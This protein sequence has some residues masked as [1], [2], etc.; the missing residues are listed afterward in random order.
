MPPG[1]IGHDGAGRANFV[2]VVKMVGAW[3]VKV[4]RAFYQTLSQYMMVKINVGLRVAG[5]GRY[6]V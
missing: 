6:M 2:P 1:E 4:N 5:D 3:I